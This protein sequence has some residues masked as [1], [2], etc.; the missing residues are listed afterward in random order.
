MPFWWRRRKRWWG[1]SRFTYGRR[2]KY[3][4]RR[5]RKTIFRRRYRRTTRGRRKRRKTKVRRKRKYLKLLQWQPQSIRKCKITGF[6]TLISG[7]NGKQFRD[8]TST[9]NNWVPPKVPGG[10]GLSI[11]RYNLEYLYEQWQ[12][13]NNI[14]TASNVDFDL[15]RYTGCKIIFFRHP[16]IDF[17]A[18]YQRYYPMTESAHTPLTAHPLLLLLQK[19]HIL[20]PSK[21]TKPHGKNYIKK[22]IKPP[23]QMTNKW[24][25]TREFAKQ[26]ILLVKAS[27]CDLNYVKM[28]KESENNL[29]NLWSLNTAFFQVGHIGTGNSTPGTPYFPLATQTFEDQRQIQYTKNG[30]SIITKI[31]NNYLSSV[32]YD[33]GWFST[34]VLNA[35][36]ITNPQTAGKPIYV[37]RYNPNIDTGKGNKI[38][39]K[40]IFADSWGPPSVESYLIVEDEPLWLAFYGWFDYINS[41]KPSYDI[42]EKYTLVIQSKYF[43]VQTKAN[44]IVPI[45]DSFVTGKS[46]YNSEP[47]TDEKNKPWLPTLKHQQ[48]TINNI[49]KCGPFIPRPE[50]RYTNWELHVKYSFFFKWG[51][52]LQTEKTVLNPTTASQ[53]PVPDKLIQTVQITNPAKQIPQTIFHTWDQRRGFLTKKALK[54]MYDYLSDE[55]TVSTDSEFHEPPTKS[56][57]TARQVPLQEKETE[58]V[59]CLQQLF[60]ESTCQE[61][62]QEEKTI[63]QLIQQQQQQQHHIKLNLIQLM[64][65]LKKTQMQM[66][67]QTGILP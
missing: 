50:G 23:E 32:S 2:R 11:S 65:N 49:V 20:I 44:F 13:H 66:Q 19:N 3:R 7:A 41:L 22:K 53:Y 62:P 59:T 29:T 46:I 56:K 5:P 64:T 17:V 48:V 47:T 61:T 36:A 1:R 8:Y 55:Q 26:S 18:Q 31:T 24:F 28:G 33:K 40:S 42:F 15:C 25:F 43:Q 6:E 67:L 45:D 27:A 9:M 21:L 54:R 12:L 58:E 38:W 37:C 39:L 63:H 10:G 4:R 51:G 14:W 35:D 34:A 52:A 57:P 60:E 30:K 16:Y